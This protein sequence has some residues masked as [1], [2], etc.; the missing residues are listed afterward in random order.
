MKIVQCIGVSGRIL[1]VQAISL[2]PHYLHM[3]AVTAEIP[4]QC[5][6]NNKDP[7][8][9]RYLGQNLINRSLCELMF[10]H[11]CGPLT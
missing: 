8:M 4:I 7:S 9:Q 6:F 5:Y 2:S 11:V 3:Q 10:M 1:I